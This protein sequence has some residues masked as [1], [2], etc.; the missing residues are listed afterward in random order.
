MKETATNGRL[1]ARASVAWKIVFTVMYRILRLADPVVRSAVANGLPGL[2]GVVRISVV[3]RQ[4][5]RPRRTLVTLL[6]VDQTW[7]VGHP[8]G[9]TGWTRN[10]E[11]AGW[12]EI[13]PPS[14]GGPRH[15][16]TR[17]ADSPERTAVIRATWTQQPF[18]ANL[19]YRL[20]ARHIAAVG[21]YFRLEPVA[22]A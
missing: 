7:Y 1:P 12:L 18:P 14:A 10:A 17:L 2:D 16:V 5:G 11:F 15:A 20:A 19:I 13:D 3:G 8:N 9:D 6:R 22:D 4:S 21:V